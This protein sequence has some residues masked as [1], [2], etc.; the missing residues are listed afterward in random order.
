MGVSEEKR[1][2]I[3]AAAQ[4]AFL[5]KGYGAAS[6]EYIAREAN[7]SKQT[8]YSHFMNKAEL[9][10]GVMHKKCEDM[11]GPLLELS[12]NAPVDDFMFAL[13][14]G[15]L[16]SLTSTETLNLYRIVVSESPRF[17]EIGEQFLQAGPK[18]GCGMIAHYIEGQVNSG[19]LKCDNSLMAAEFFCDMAKGT[20]HLHAVLGDDLPSVEQRQA[21]AKECVRV[22]MAAYGA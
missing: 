6:M 5:E 7:V 20:V 12:E 4:A 14:V 10:V 22:F 19:V 9:F 15:L 3:L 21:R 16:E 2:D 11:R 17:P 1:F 8:L 18:D 13:A